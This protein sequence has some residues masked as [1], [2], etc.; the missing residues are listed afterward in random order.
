MS[1]CA[2]GIDRVLSDPALGHAVAA[3]GRRKLQQRFGW[4]AV[5]AQVT[6]AMKVRPV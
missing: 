1:S 5:A 3:C 6:E 2:W 4:D